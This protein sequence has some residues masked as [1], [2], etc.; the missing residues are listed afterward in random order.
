MKASEAFYKASRY[1]NAEKSAAQAMGCEAAVA[2]G[3]LL[4]AVFCT[5]AAPVAIPVATAAIAMAVVT[6]ALVATAETN[7]FFFR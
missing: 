5:A 3:G 4:C 7:R 2:I 1:K 6:G